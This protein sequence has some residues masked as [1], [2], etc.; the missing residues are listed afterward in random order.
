MHTKNFVLLRCPFAFATIFIIKKRPSWERENYR[1]PKNFTQR[2]LY[3]KQLLHAVNVETKSWNKHLIAVVHQ[4]EIHCKVYILI[5][6][7]SHV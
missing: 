2:R 1:Q 5:V 3:P 6:C 4:G 7:D